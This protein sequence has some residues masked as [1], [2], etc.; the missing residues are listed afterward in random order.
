MIIITPFTLLQ[1]V[2]YMWAVD[3]FLA[4]LG[5][6]WVWHPAE[7]NLP[8]ARTSRICLL[9]TLQGRKRFLLPVTFFPMKL[10][11]LFAL[12]VTGIKMID[13]SKVGKIQ[14]FGIYQNHFKRQM[15]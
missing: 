8:C 11:Y 12:Q 4:L 7:I 1:N 3:R 9:F 5:L 10:V 6:K 15:A 14:K 2:K 13:I